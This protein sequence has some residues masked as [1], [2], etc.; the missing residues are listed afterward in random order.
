[1]NCEFLFF[2]CGLK[3]FVCWV[4]GEWGLGVGGVE[5]IVA[6]LNLPATSRIFFFFFFQFFDIIKS[7]VIFSPKRLPKLV[8]ICTRKH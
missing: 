3:N 7:L 1:M 2:F 6:G 8:E 4:W 5:G